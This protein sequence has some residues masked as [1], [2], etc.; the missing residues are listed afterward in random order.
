[1]NGRVHN[2]NISRIRLPLPYPPPLAKTLETWFWSVYSKEEVKAELSKTVRPE[3]AP[4][5]IPT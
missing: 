2:R 5:L 4:A 1:M 3:N